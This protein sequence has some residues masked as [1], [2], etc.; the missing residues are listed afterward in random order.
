MEPSADEA[1][2][3]ITSPGDHSL[4]S[5]LHF[6]D[7]TSDYSLDYELDSDPNNLSE[8]T[9]HSERPSLSHASQSEPLLHHFSDDP[10]SQLG[11]SS[12]FYRHHH[13]DPTT[14]QAHPDLEDTLPLSAMYWSTA[15]TFHQDQACSSFEDSRTTSYTSEDMVMSLIPELT[16]GPP[17]QNARLPDMESS[18]FTEILRRCIILQQTMKSVRRVQ[19]AIV[20]DK[21]T[22]PDLLR[23]MYDT[24]LES[25]EFVAGKLE[26]L[27]STSNRV[28]RNEGAFFSAA[29]TMVHQ[30]L[31]V[32]D[33]LVC[34][35]KSSW[36]VH[37]LKRMEVDIGQLEAALSTLRPW[38]DVEVPA[39]LSSVARDTQTVLQRIQR[40]VPT[41]VPSCS[42][43]W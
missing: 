21:V 9:W 40:V 16:T 18:D 4:Q 2:F 6:G 5:C 28:D 15:T 10:L 26:H 39:L 41:S 33:A 20:Q 36:Q 43:G 13:L 24:F 17:F 27:A 22:K 14:E 31:A 30:I 23:P 32:S 8:R 42:S 34:I 35:Y 3:D 12:I 1:Q 37:M 38:S 29:L 25:I 11:P 7:F 19:S